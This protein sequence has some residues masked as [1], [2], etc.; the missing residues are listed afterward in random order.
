MAP[1]D[2]SVTVKLCERSPGVLECP[3]VDSVSYERWKDPSRHNIRNNSRVTVTGNIVHIH[4]V[5]KLDE[6][7]FTNVQFSTQHGK[8]QCTINVTVMG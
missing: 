6:G 1:R 7:R 8:I 3:R 4:Q 2:V 5:R